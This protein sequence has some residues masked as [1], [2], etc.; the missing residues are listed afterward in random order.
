VAE[1]SDVAP[2]PGVAPMSGVA[3]RPAVPSLPGRKRRAELLT[4]A[5][6]YFSL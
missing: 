3:P 1:A 5:D 4:A 2:A 6:G